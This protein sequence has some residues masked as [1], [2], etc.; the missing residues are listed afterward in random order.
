VS[1]E[2]RISSNKAVLR[3][4][5]RACVYCS[6]RS[7]QPL[8]H[9]NHPSPAPLTPLHTHTK[10]GLR[11][12]VET[13]SSAVRPTLPFVTTIILTELDIRI[14]P[15][16]HR[17]SRPR[18]STSAIAT[19]S[20]HLPSQLSLTLAW[21]HHLATQIRSTKART[22]TRPPPCQTSPS[23]S[24]EEDDPIDPLLSFDATTPRDP[25]SSP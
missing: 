14:P 10:E 2:R 17:Y 3:H 9:Q 24:Q 12:R 4:R 21:L 8:R 11:Y 16:T 6:R 15:R 20:R 13:S 25:L 1:R 7:F 23:G 5:A 19:S 22:R 18:P